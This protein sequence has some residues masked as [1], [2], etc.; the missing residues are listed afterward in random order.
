[1]VATRSILDRQL[2]GSCPFCLT[3]NLIP[4]DKIVKKA[5]WGY[6]VKEYSQVIPGTL[7]VV[8]KWH[9]MNA[10]KWLLFLWSFFWLTRREGLESCNISLNMGEDAGQTL[11]HPHVWVV[12]RYG[13]YTG[14]GLAH[15]V[16]L[17]ATSR[18]KFKLS[19][20]EVVERFTLD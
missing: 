17:E 12:P 11:P 18:N 19:L 15:F 6:L 9:Q 10:L 5:S 8:P 2:D 4:Q 16:A 7:Q 13:K 20:Q 1:M 3:N 14:K